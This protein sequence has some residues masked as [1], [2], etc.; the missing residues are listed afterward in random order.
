MAKDLNKVLIIGRL[1]AEPDLRYTPQGAAVCTMRVASGRSWRDERG[2]PHDETEWFRVVAWERLGE[3]CNQFLTKGSRVYFEG[4]LK[5]NKWQD[6]QGMWHERVEVHVT[7]MILLDTRPRDAAPAADPGRP[8]V[9]PGDDEV[10]TPPPRAAAP[11]TPP[12]TARVPGVRKS[13]A[14]AVVRP[15]IPKDIEDDEDLPF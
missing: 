8:E 6:D 10:F 12:Q 3:T 14:G 1:G 5:T 13:A 11:P 7:E 9:E 4:R 15:S 2:E